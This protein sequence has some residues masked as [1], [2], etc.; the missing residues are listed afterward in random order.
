MRRDQAT[1]EEGTNLGA[2]RT[3]DEEVRVPVGMPPVRTVARPDGGTTSVRADLGEAGDERPAVL[4]VHGWTVTADTTFAPC[5]PALA[6]RYRV[7]APDLRGH[8]HSSPAPHGTRLEDLADDCAAVLDALAVERAIVV[9]YSLGGAV[10]QL[11][12]LR[13]RE[14]VAGLV[15]C[16]TARHFQTGPVGDLWYRG[17]SWIAP[18]VRA[19]PGP[20]RARMQRAVHGK[21]GPGPYAAWYRQELLRGDPPS[22]LRLGAALGRF[23]SNRWIGE[24]DVPAAAIVTTEDRTVPTRRQRGLA[25]AIPGC[26]VYE[27]AGPHNSAVSIPDVWVPQLRAALDGLAPDDRV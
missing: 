2:V 9:G 1:V 27:V 16:S 3:V 4:L 6:D 17:Q 7:V 10:A 5:Y 26:T 19:F 25:A 14:R 22:L 13:H 18:A 21:V 24:V 11:L 15:V 12:W 23:R 8:G 20:A